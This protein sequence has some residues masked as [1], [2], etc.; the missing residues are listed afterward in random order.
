MIIKPGVDFSMLHP[1]IVRGAWVVVEEFAAA[2]Y[3][4]GLTSGREG[5]HGAGSFHVAAPYGLAVDLDRPD[6]F[7][8]EAAPAGYD[9]GAILRGVRIRLGPLFQLVWEDDH[10]HLEADER[11]LIAS[12]VRP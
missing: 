4:I 3:P 7:Q 11:A 8:A 2:G 1:W 12:K 5:P 9:E 10:Y 6:R